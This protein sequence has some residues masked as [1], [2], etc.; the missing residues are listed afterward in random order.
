MSVGAEERDGPS[1]E[2]TV[3]GVRASVPDGA[4]LVE[5][6]A[7]TSGATGAPPDG[8]GIAV[9]LEDTV[10]PAGAWATT[11]VAPGARV[12]VLRAVAGG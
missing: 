2:I 9:A 7:A 3:N 12:E 8:R 5:V 4:S 1:V 11:K 6:L 10:V